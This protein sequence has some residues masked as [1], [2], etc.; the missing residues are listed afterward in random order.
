MVQSHRPRRLL[1]SRKEAKLLR[2][3][4]RLARPRQAPLARRTLVTARAVDEALRLPRLRRAK[5]AQMRERNC[6]HR[7]ANHLR[8]DLDSARRL[9]LRMLANSLILLALQPPI[10]SEQC[11]AP[12]PG[13]RR[14]PGLLR[15]LWKTRRKAASEFLR[16]LLGSGRSL[17]LLHHRVATPGQEDP[18]LRPH[19]R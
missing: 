18:R 12:T 11:R 9:Q 1:M 13:R 8:P 10:A 19:G 4:P 5:R 14:L 7:T 17:L 3:L 6:L 15:P 2:R 16:L